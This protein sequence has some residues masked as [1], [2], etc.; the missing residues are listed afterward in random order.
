MDPKFFRKYADIV[1]SAE[2]NEPVLTE[3]MLTEGIID[4]IVQKAKGIVSKIPSDTLAKVTDLVT[5]ALGKPA[6]QL[7]IKDITMANVKKVVAANNQTAVTEEDQNVSY[8]RKGI[9]RADI[10]GSKVKNQ[11]SNA[12]VGGVLGLIVPMLGAV[13]VGVISLPITLLAAACAIAFAIFGAKVATADRGATGNYDYSKAVSGSG[14]KSNWRDYKRDPR[15]DGKPL[16]PQKDD[17]I[18][19]VRP[20]NPG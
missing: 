8:D 4:T 20:K 14:G 6:D 17:N 3:S 13:A 18:F 7:S 2:K 5:T 9:E 12:A 1:E 16:P 10:P 15:L 11:I 19:A